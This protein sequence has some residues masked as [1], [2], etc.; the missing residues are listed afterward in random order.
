MAGG[1]QQAV[2]TERADQRQVVGAPRPQARGRLDQRVLRDPGKDALGVAQQV[3]HPADGDGGVEADLGLGGAQHDPVRA[4]HQVERPAVDQRTHRPRGASGRR[5]D[6]ARGAGSRPSPAGPGRA[7]PGAARRSAP[8]RRRGRCPPPARSRR[9]GGRRRR[10]SRRPARPP[11]RCRRTPHRPARPRSAGRRG[12]TRLSTARSSGTDSPP[13]TSGPSP[14]S[15]R[16]SSR[17]VSRSTGGPAGPGARRGCRARRGR[18]SPWRRRSCRPCAARRG[19]RRRPRARRRRRASGRPTP[20]PS[21]EQLLL[22]RPGLGH[23]GEHAA[24]HPGGPGR[25]RRVEDGDPVAVLRGPPGAAQADHAGAHHQQLCRVLV[26]HLA[27]CAGMTRIRFDGRDPWIPSQPPVGAPVR[28][29]IRTLRQTARPPLR[30]TAYRRRPPTTAA[31]ARTRRRLALRARLADARLYLCTDA[32]RSRG[33]LAEFADAALA[34]GVDI[35]QLRDKGPT[36][37]SRRATSWRP[38]RCWPTPAPGT[39]RCSR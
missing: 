34:G 3:A 14:G 17:P 32:R 8:P 21:A 27:P 7:A 39:V 5:R 25:G 29:L 9:R 12:R 4:G 15:S 33:D 2:G 36:G 20:T 13:R 16:R 26:H 30:A 6:A 22:A 35:V 31:R 38:W 11:P 1:D 10:A 18:R 37:R 24:R 19:V 28:H 23:R